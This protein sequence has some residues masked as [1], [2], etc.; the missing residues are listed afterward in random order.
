MTEKLY[1]NDAYGRDFSALIKKVSYTGDDRWL[2]ECDRTLF[3]PEEGGQSSDT[4]YLNGY[5]VTHVSIDDEGIITH[6]VKAGEDAF[7]EGM[8]IM[9]QI[10]WDRR[11][12][13]MQNHT[14]EH[15]LSG[16]LHE[17]WGS[18]NVGFHLSDNTVTLDTSRSLTKEDLAVLERR[19]N[20]VVYKDLPV[21]CRYYDAKEL[22]DI[23]YRSKLTFKD[24]A[25]LVVIPGVDIC[26]CCAPHVGHTGEI[27]LIRIIKA[28]NYKGGMRL[29][30]LSG[31][32]A[33]EYTARSH[34]IIE[35]LSHKLSEA[36]DK[37]AE[38][39]E[40]LQKEIA[41]GKEREAARS[42]AALA[43][44]V[45]SVPVDSRDAVIFADDMDNISQR[46]AVNRLAENHKGICAVFAGLDG[47]YRFIISYPEGDARDVAARLKEKLDARGGGSKEMVQGS[48]SS[49][50]AEIKKVISGMTD[51][52]E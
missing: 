34:E 43:D 9:G 25:R 27:G 5:E 30:I 33:Y 7:L 20:E 1:D 15:I 46:N 22:E 19:A 17:I 24:S 4:G 52:G 42:R 45:A 47:D 50:G 8:R 28:I 10:D 51:P 44:L 16:L 37:L 21:L 49:T 39:V 31:R 38:A 13:N 32:R 6:E 29:S 2:V 36:P 11:F 35:E 14:G 48:I 40:R 18:E 23:E 41:L 26:A 12:S 3:F